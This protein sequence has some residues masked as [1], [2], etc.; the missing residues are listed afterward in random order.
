MAN[1]KKIVLGLVAALAVAVA[2]CASDGGSGGSGGSAGTAG[3]GG[4]T[5]GAGGMSDMAM[6]RVAHL[7]PDI[8]S[9]E[10]T[11]VDILVN[12]ETAITDLT[13]PTNSGFAMLPPGEYTFGV[14]AAGSTDPVL[15]VGPV[16]LEAGD[17]LNAIAY[18]DEDSTAP[19]PVSVFAIPGGDDSPDGEGTV[20]VAHGAEAD[21]L[22]PVNVIDVVPGACPPALIPDFEFGT[23]VGPLAFPAT[24]LNIAFNL[25]GSPECQVD[26][27]PLSGAVAPDQTTI[28]VAV[29]RDT[30]DPI[31]PVV[32]VMNDETAAGP[33]GSLEPTETAQVRIAHLAPEVPSAEDTAVDILINGNPA[34]TGLE[35]GNATGFVDLPVGEYTFGIAVAGETEPVFEVTTEILVGSQ[36]TFV[37]YRTVD[38]DFDS[39]VA[40][41]PFDGD[42][43]GINEGLG[44]VL[45]GHGAD[46]ALLKP[47]DVI[48]PGACPP[49]TIEDFAFG[50]VA[51]PLDLPATTIP[52]A[53]SLTST[54][55]CSVDAGPLDA[56]VTEGIVTLLVAVDNDTSE[57]LSPAVY[58]LIGDASGEIPTLSP[59]N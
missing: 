10:N 32:Y 59:S 46:D 34:I 43:E 2:G 23:T 35:F 8:P 30:G 42:A 36:T 19:V 29:D 16:T 48:T 47:V 51:G 54:D 37:A 3:A 45:V 9:A 14:A 44:R 31:D 52:I 24:T 7:A 55:E 18:R 58:A 33:L 4:G 38:G 17:I 39:P 26:A 1:T 11:A 49:P 20:W 41:M 57:G 50:A 56:P 40:V 21:V 28:L 27:G 13:F 22:D 12:G 15:E 25:D 53:F 5:G 6:V